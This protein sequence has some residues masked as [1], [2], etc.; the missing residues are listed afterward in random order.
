MADHDQYSKP[1]ETNELLAAVPGVAE[2][3]PVIGIVS[4]HNANAILIEAAKEDLVTWPYHLY[5]TFDRLPERERETAY[6]AFDKIVSAAYEIGVGH[7]PLNAWDRI[8]LANAALMRRARE[9]TLGGGRN[10]RRT[11][12]G[13]QS[14]IPQSQT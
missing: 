7:L 1:A 2:K 8:E 14:R 12:D 5:Q 3:V 9:K 4:V 11:R 13:H 10:C 6:L